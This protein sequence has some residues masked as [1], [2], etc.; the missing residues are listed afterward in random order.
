[1]ET[2]PPKPGTHDLRVDSANPQNS[3]PP[4]TKALVAQSASVQLT[5]LTLYALP[6]LL[7]LIA[8]GTSGGFLY[9]SNFLLL[10]LQVTTQYLESLRESFA[11]F[12]IPFVTAYSAAGPKRDG[13]GGLGQLALFFI[14]AAL[15]V[16]SI[17][18]L[19]FLNVRSNDFSL[20]FELEP[21]A[22]KTLY[23]HEQTLLTA[24]TKELLVY[25]SLLIGIGVGKSL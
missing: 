24:Y 13:T 1:M 15:L 5:L 7:F 22:I 8:A 16:V 9:K 4:R 6:L 14:L 19:G 3:V 25:I 11:T 12:V 18:L 20:I 10:T 17:V 2:F 21:E 23:E